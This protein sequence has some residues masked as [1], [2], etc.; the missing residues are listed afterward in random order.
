M[1]AGGGARISSARTATPRHRWL[2][3]EDEVRLV[4]VRV[5]DALEDAVNAL[6]GGDPQARRRARRVLSRYSDWQSTQVWEG[7]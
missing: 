6:G 4:V 5:G 1:S 7:A 2:R 3:P